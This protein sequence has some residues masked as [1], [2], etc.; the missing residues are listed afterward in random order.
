[1]STTDNDTND[2][3]PPQVLE[4]DRRNIVAQF[5][6]LRAA[7]SDA[8]HGFGKVPAQEFIL[9]LLE[10]ELAAK[11][12]ANLMGHARI[13]FGFHLAAQ[14]RAQAAVAAAQAQDTPD[15]EPQRSRAIMDDYSR[16]RGERAIPPDSAGSDYDRDPDSAIPPDSAG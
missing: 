12:L 15:R 2:K 11:D 8:T 1:M 5:D 16:P 3:G 9:L 6:I 13:H 7:W 14:Q 4:Q 10:A